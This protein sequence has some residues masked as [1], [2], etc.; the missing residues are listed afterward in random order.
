MSDSNL[1]LIVDV[2]VSR[3][4]Q[5]FNRLDFTSVLFITDEQVFPETVKQ[6]SRTAD[7]LTDGFYASSPTYKAVRSY[8]SQ[9]PRPR[10]ITIGRRKA[11][12]IEYSMVVAQVTNDTEYTV[13]INGTAFTYTSASDAEDDKPAE[14]QAIM[15]GLEA[16]ITA[17]I[18]DFDGAITVDSTG[19]GASAVLTITIVDPIGISHDNELMT[20][21]YDHA[22]WADTLADIQLVD[23]NWYALATYDHT[24]AGSLAIAS[25][26]ETLR[27]IYLVSNSHADNI[28]T[29]AVPA[30]D[31]DLLGKLNEFNYDRTAFI[32]SATAD[33]TYIEMAYLGDKM[34]TVA[35]STTWDLSGVA[36]VV[37]DNLTRTQITNLDTKKGNYFTA[38]GGVDYIR[39]GRMV[40][41]EWIDVMRGSD[42]LALDIQAEVARVIASANN[43]G[44][45]IPLTD[46]GVAILADCV[47]LVTER[48]VARNFIKDQILEVDANG[49]TYTRKGY[50]VEYAPVSTLTTT[51]RANREAPDIQVVADLAGAVHHARVLIN[52][53]V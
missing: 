37:A 4:V 11:D 39:E 7:L 23:N 49:Q 35:G 36:G 17:D 50:T 13:N 2:Q 51:Q 38:F 21:T 19:T 46:E 16:L 1:D 26:I 3:D 52:L 30:G 12:E 18:A 6:Y 28:G 32:Y 22:T 34:T 25:E 48:Y 15:Q 41:G 20:A 44:R 45:K 24:V 10:Q 33:E 47:A 8:F 14:I 43:A 40:S 9:S 29:Q 27:K 5:P 53:F 42:N 31:N